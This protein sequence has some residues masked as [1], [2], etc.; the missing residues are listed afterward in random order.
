MTA[1]IRRI[2][3]VGGGA[4]GT[5]LALLAARAKLHPTLWV[6]E[7]EVAAAIAAGRDN[8][9]LPGVALD[10]AIN[11]TTDFDALREC[12]ALLLA[13]PAQ[14]LRSVCRSLR[15]NVRSG[16]PIT[17]CSKGIEET[18]GALL[19]EVVATELPGAPI[20]VLSGPTFAPEI[21]RDLPA[22]VTL[23]CR[24]AEI[25][26]ALVE[27]IG[28]PT[29]RPYF[30]E[31]IIGAQVGG[32]VKNVIAI[33][34]G[35]VAGRKM[36]DNARAALVTRG[37]AEIQRLGHALHARPATLMGLSGLGDLVLTCSSEQSRNYS[38]GIALGRGKKTAEIVASQTSVAEGVATAAAVV[39][40]AARLK[41]EMPI[42]AAVDAIVNKSAAIDQA[43]QA[44][45]ARPFRAE[46][47]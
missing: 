25:G 45:L 7:P 32:G 11:A 36:G 27:A 6:R 43:I 44:L 26:K 38:L 10:A 3:V 19:S 40:R 17:I 39:C 47:K 22:A 41:I 12:D 33:A 31:D 8:P 15:P 35:I 24:D 4:W 2:G 1:A 46:G 20:A 34:C 16:A 21:A 42:S 13:A 18:S 37:L 23:A 28:T 30:S 14:H 5:T 9:F 29:F